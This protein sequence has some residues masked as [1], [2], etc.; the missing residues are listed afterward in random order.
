MKLN[1]ISKF[2]LGTLAVSTMIAIGSMPEDASSKRYATSTLEN[3]P[4]KMQVET[5]TYCLTKSGEGFLS[6]F[7]NG[8]CNSNV[9]K[10]KF[11]DNNAQAVMSDVNTVA[12]NFYEGKS[13]TVYKLN[14][15]AE[16]NL[17]DINFKPRGFTGRQVKSKYIGIDYSF[18]NDDSEIT[19]ATFNMNKSTQPKSAYKY[20]FDG[21]IN[22]DDDLI[23]QY[24][25]NMKTYE[26]ALK[27]SGGA[28]AVLIIGLFISFLGY[29]K[30][31]SKKAVK[32]VIKAHQDSKVA[33]TARL[34]AVEETVRASMANNS[35]A[36]TKLALMIADALD[37]GDTDT[38]KVLSETL[39]QLD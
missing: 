20:T 5:N 31:K 25:K 24:H 36:K 23:N 37:K 18:L 39:K 13:Y 3:L 33:E 28:I 32:S 1:L 10:I 38:A 14:D 21:F 8:R 6:I 34:V 30:N 17:T 29:L 19:V 26:N 22:Q 12:L 7:K 16:F 2:G 4:V 11:I 27:T 9:S 15:N 35:E